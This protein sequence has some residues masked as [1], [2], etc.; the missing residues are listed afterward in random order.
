MKTKILSLLT[1]ILLVSCSNSDKDILN[2]ISSNLNNIKTVK[3]L[4]VV[5]QKNK[6]Q[7]VYQNKDTI[8][9][10]FTNGLKYHFSS[11]NG[12]LIYNGKKILQSINQ[13]KIITT[14]DDY[15]PEL[16]NNQLFNTLN[17]LKQI[18]PKLIQ[19]ESIIK[20]R[21]KDTV[22]NGRDYFNF[23][24]LLKKKYIDFISYE[25]KEG[26]DYDS[27][28][29]L[30]VDK[31]NYLPYKIISPNGKE[32]LVTTTIENVELNIEFKNNLWEG[33][34]LPKDYAHFTLKEYFA[35]LDNNILNS[36]GKEL[37]NW[38]LPELKSNKLV[39]LSKL[40]GNVILLE[41][42]FKYC[43]GCVMAI[44]DLNKIKTKFEK[45]NFKIYGVEF[46]EN[47][48]KDDLK[49][50]ITDQKILYPNLYKGKAIASNYGIRSAPTFMIIDK[51]GT[52]I[53]IKSGFSEENMNE[54]IEIIEKNI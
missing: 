35:S 47:Y 26:I 10:D 20:S 28:Y 16:I 49:K 8:S 6:G 45:D 14:N 31:T 7:I 21:K 43:G 9:F 19:D 41:F 29:S 51:N 27:E 33:E 48:S 2:K 52:I 3:Y 44:P 13:E 11:E 37:T 17:Y 1:V 5:E 36:L 54:I 34:L 42:W 23:S 18:L 15:K 50:Y 40:K 22:L 24:F 46:I 38:E 12:E 53:H 30:I 39:N 32:G 4:S 25:F